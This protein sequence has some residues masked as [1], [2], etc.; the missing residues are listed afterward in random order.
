M[1]MH[2]K[3]PHL[4]EELSFETL[5]SIQEQQERK[6]ITLKKNRTTGS[7]SSSSSSSSSSIVLKPSALSGMVDLNSPNAYCGK[8]VVDPFSGVQPAYIN[9]CT[10]DVPR[11]LTER[12]F[13]HQ[14]EGLDWLAAL[15][16]NCPGGILGDDMGMGKTFTVISFLTS[17]FR[18]HTIRKVLI[19][20]PVSVLESWNREICNHCLPHVHK[21]YAHLIASDVSKSK[22][23]SILEDVLLSQSRTKKHICVSSYTLMSNGIASF[24][25]EE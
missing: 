18:T 21:C 9:T 17:L 16:T 11:E 14:K 3:K 20:C 13:G 4:V 6:K 1:D 25:R 5:K 7:N 12:M 19:L 23:E 15:H 10:M 24:A 8:Y 22:R 2:K